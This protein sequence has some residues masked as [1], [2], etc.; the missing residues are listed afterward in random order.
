MASNRKTALNCNTDPMLFTSPIPVST[1]LTSPALVVLWQA[2]V[3]DQADDHEPE[4]VPTDLALDFSQGQSADAFAAS[5]PASPTAEVDDTNMVQKKRKIREAEAQ[6]ILPD[7]EGTSAQQVWQPNQHTPSNASILQA[8][9]HKP[10]FVGH[11]HESG[12]L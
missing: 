12:Q 8:G 5:A 1:L 7:M 6:P 3:E 4:T 11:L 2:V 9:R 10:A